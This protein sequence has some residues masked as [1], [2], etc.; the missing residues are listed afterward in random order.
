MKGFGRVRRG[1]LAVTIMLVSSAFGC[2]MSPPAAMA[3]ETA[4]EAIRENYVPPDRKFD[5][6]ALSPQQQIEV[7]NIIRYFI[8]HNPE[9]I[10]EVM[11]DGYRRSHTR[12]TAR[13]EERTVIDVIDLHALPE[14]TIR[15]LFSNP[16][17]P[18]DGNLSPDAPTLI[19]FFDYSCIYCKASKPV[20]TEFLSRNP[21][22]RHIYKDL[23]L[24]GPEALEAA[25]VGVVL[26]QED[27]RLYHEY[28]RHMMKLRGTPNR[29][30]VSRF[31]AEHG[32]DGREILSKANRPEIQRHLE[33]TRKLATSFGIQGTPAIL[34]GDTL[35]TKVPTREELEEVLDRIRASRAPHQEKM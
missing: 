8:E 3:Q 12:T 25:R 7:L 6:E 26:A 20:I 22:V 33:A 1:V 17:D 4:F 32:L 28:H 14:D 29:T 16:I 23:P 5:V 15:E 21:E 27:M 11:Q 34:L 24:L 13:P 30:A 2:P 10:Y 9:L 19:E 31:L 35:F 18:V